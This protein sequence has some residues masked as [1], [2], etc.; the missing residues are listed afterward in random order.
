M[1]VLLITKGHP[2]DRGPFF[3]MFDALPEVEWTHVEHP[4]AQA[5]IVSGH[6]SEYD[7]LVFYDM[8]GLSFND[9]R[10]PDL[11]E[12]GLAFQQSLM[13]MVQHG[14]GFVFL[15]HAIAGWPTWD[16][17]AE[18]LGGRFLYLPKRLR[19][20]P[21]MDSGYRHD[22]TYNVRV[23]AEHPVTANVPT[24]FPVTDELY[25][26]E[27]FD[28]SIQPLLR[29]DYTFTQDNFHSAA[30]AVAEQRMFC[31]DGWCHPPGSDLVGWTREPANSRVVYLQFGDGPSAY[32]NEHLRVILE[33]AIRWASGGRDIPQH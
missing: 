30:L 15:H 27:V 10:A 19:D 17:Y 5:L 6:A 24:A 28:D 32:T 7:A 11:I 9:H 2:F 22:V 20:V 13:A 18:L 4:A 33:N 16:D 25:L 23:V 26:F 8:P 3:E 21:R 1:K 12:P 31:N 29:A 14:H